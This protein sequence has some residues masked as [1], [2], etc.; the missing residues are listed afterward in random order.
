MTNSSLGMI[1]IL[2][3]T[4]TWPPNRR[5]C[6][7]F[8]TLPYVPCNLLYLCMAY[9]YFYLAFLTYELTGA[10]NVHQLKSVIHIK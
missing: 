3:P 2:G 4:T 7:A 6:G 5:V 8:G 9:L 1:R 10:S